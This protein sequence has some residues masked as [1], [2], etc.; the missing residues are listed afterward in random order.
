[1]EKRSELRRNKFLSISVFFSSDFNLNYG[2]ST[3]Q[4]E[5]IAYYSPSCT[6]ILEAVV[7]KHIN[8]Q[9][10]YTLSLRNKA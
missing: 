5:K 7:A 3:Q 2:L 10:A 8:S 4:M 6:T 9:H 1:M